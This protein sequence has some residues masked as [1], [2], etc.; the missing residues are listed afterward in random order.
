MCIRDRCHAASKRKARSEGPRPRGPSGTFYAAARKITLCIAFPSCTS[1]LEHEI[2]LSRDLTETGRISSYSSISISFKL[3]FAE[4]E[5]SNLDL[6][7]SL[8][9]SQIFSQSTSLGQEY[10]V[11]VTWNV[12]TFRFAHRARLLREMEKS[13]S[14]HWILRG[15]EKNHLLHCISTLHKPLGTWNSPF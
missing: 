13:A 5:T 11:N 2:H 7:L 3:M 12:E 6:N 1:H 15:C 9:L 10:M 8:P 14:H 4:S